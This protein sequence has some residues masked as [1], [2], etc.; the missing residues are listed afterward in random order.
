MIIEGKHLKTG[1]FSAPWWMKKGKGG[2]CQKRNVHDSVNTLQYFPKNFLGGWKQPHQF[3]V[4][5]FSESNASLCGD[6]YK[7]QPT[8]VCSNMPTYAL[9]YPGVSRGSPFSP[10][11]TEC[12]WG[13]HDMASF[14][15]AKKN[16]PQ[17]H[18][19]HKW[20]IAVKLIRMYFCISVLRVNGIG[21]TRVSLLGN[22]QPL[23]FCFG[24][25]KL[26]LS[27]SALSMATIDAFEG[28]KAYLLF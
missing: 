25:L 13:P 10:M 16:T 5:L 7:Y 19:S 27:T 3:C 9:K 14:L 28:R 26:V 8:C 1:A 11:D 4:T 23:N 17:Y 22:R 20:K 6:S 15:L 21:S 12:F 24:A 18:E 2:L